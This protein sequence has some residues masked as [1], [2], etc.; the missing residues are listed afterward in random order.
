MYVKLYLH[1]MSCMYVLPVCQVIVI[2]HSRGLYAIYKPE[3]R[4]HSP[5]DEGLCIAYKARYWSITSF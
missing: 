3:S 2:D 1:I 5:R 4:G